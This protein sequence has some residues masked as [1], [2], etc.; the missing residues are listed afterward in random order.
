[1]DPTFHRRTDII[2]PDNIEVWESKDT[3]G[4]TLL[5]NYSSDEYSKDFVES[6][7][8]EYM[9]NDPDLVAVYIDEA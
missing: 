5:V 2:L 6:L 8:Q 9:N 1:M 4:T 3:H 7:I